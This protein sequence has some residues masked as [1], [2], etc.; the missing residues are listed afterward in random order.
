MPWLTARPHGAQ[1]LK[2][3][4]SFAAA[5]EIPRRQMTAP[6]TDD[7]GNEIEISS[8]EKELSY[9]CE[10]TKEVVDTTTL[11]QIV[12]YECKNR[13]RVSNLVGLPSFEPIDIREN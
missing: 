11:D 6:G 9:F 7:T 2:S 4:D 12:V 5:R 1:E 8:H 3:R 13:S 10:A